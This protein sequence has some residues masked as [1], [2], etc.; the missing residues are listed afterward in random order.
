MGYLKAPEKT[1]DVMTDDHWYRT[2]DVGK[3]DS[4]GNYLLFVTLKACLFVQFRIRV[5]NWSY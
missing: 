3:I 1:K 5:G 2:G 4:E